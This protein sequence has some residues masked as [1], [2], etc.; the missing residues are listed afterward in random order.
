MNLSHVRLTPCRTR[1]IGG[2]TS[3]APLMRRHR[4]KA[5]P[6]SGHGHPKR[7]SEGCLADAI[8]AQRTA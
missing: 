6:L 5:L 1:L 8:G 4:A 2:G 3:S 7:N